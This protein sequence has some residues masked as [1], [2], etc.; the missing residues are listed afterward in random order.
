MCSDTQSVSINASVASV[1]D[2]VGEISALPRWAVGFAREVVC[3][4]GQWWV[5][6]GHGEVAIDLVIDRDRGVV[7]F[8]MSPA[9]G[10]D[11][12]AFSRV[13]PRGEASEYV[14]T[15]FQLPDM[16]DQVFDGQVAALRHELTV[17]KALVEVECPL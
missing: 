15:Q 7:D 4:D 9:P 5:K 10:V 3:R 6:T 1:L 14:F 2:V 11:A 12:T 17:L 16:P 13:L 8:R